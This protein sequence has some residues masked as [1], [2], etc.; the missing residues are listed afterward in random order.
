MFNLFRASKRNS[1]NFRFLSKY[2]INAKCKNIL[3][4]PQKPNQEG[5]NNKLQFE[6]NT[7]S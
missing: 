6:R 7:N 4:I 3:I 1:I 5:I 2:L